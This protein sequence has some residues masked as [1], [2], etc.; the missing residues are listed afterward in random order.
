MFDKFMPRICD[1][2]WN[3]G[4]FITCTWV[5]EPWPLSPRTWLG[6][7][8]RPSP[9]TGPAWQCR[10]INL[11]LAVVKALSNLAEACAELGQVEAG[12]A[13]STLLAELAT[14]GSALAEEFHLTALYVMPPAADH[15]DTMTEF[16][17]LPDLLAFLRLE[18]RLAE[19]LRQTVKLLPRDLVDTA[20][21]SNLR[22]V[23]T[24][25]QPRDVAADHPAS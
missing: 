11:A 21:A 19:R 1:Y 7:A 23:W 13:Y 4:G 14:V 3:G 5:T 10:E 17:P 22:V 25:Q 12:A 20:A 9:P 2:G 16:R 15:L 24:T 18:E 8:Q 6:N